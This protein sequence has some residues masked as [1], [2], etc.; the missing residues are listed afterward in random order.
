MIKKYKATFLD[1]FQTDSLHTKV[2]IAVFEV[3]IGPHNFHD[4][5]FFTADEFEGYDIDSDEYFR[6]CYQLTLMA[7]S[8]KVN[9]KQIK[10]IKCLVEI[11][12][13]RIIGVYPTNN[14]KG[15]KNVR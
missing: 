11:E 10:G 13:S 8:K 4:I 14:L 5:L 9:F 7:N 2:H 12:G 1:Y 3:N 6:F 15:V